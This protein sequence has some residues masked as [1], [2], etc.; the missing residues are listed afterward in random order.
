MKRISKLPELLKY[1]LHCLE[2]GTIPVAQEMVQLKFFE[3]RF[4]RVIGVD[5]VG[6]GCLAGPVM[7][8]AVSYDLNKLTSDQE[9]SLSGLNDSKKITAK[10]RERLSGIIRATADFAVGHVSNQDVDRFNILNAS[11]IAM[12][13]A[14]LR[15]VR[16]LENENIDQSAILI[17]V[18]GKKPLPAVELAQLPITKGDGKS[19][20]IASASII[21]KVTRD[22]LMTRYNR[23]YPDY[24]WTQNKGYPS[25][26]H[27]E[28]L[29]KWGPSPLH[30]QT[31]N[32]Q[33]KRA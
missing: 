1:D 13:K 15:L 29:E 22:K 31:F 12:E 26:S 11:M 21:A 33:R 2:H 23:R 8:A 7:A 30:R 18:D 9:T 5:E 17:L 3:R 4:E 19:A 28:A 27:V 16:K 32:W 25:A 24:A 20:S 10:S 14:V 6:R